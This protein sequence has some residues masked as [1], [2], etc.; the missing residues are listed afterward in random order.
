M[1]Q[2]LNF[3]TPFVDHVAKKTY[4]KTKNNDLQENI[5]NEH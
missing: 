1:I 5:D 4:I 2:K 3:G